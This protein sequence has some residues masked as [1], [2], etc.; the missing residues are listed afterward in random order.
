TPDPRHPGGRA[1][2]I[3]APFFDQ[4][5]RFAERS[6]IFATRLPDR[7]VDDAFIIEF[8]G[9]VLA[10]HSAFDAID[11]DGDARRGVAV[12]AADAGLRTLHG[13][14]DREELQPAG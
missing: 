4:A 10:W 1:R 7:I 6:R 11:A 8:A 3:N 2:K 5:R 14:P 13:W 12:I 9:Q